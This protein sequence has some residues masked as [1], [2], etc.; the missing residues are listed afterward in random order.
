M[1]T[2]AEDTFQDISLYLD[3]QEIEPFEDGESALFTGHTGQRVVKLL[4]DYGGVHNIPNILDPSEPGFTAQSKVNRIEKIT[5]SQDEFEFCLPE[6]I[7][8]GEDYMEVEYVDG[9]PLNDYLQNPEAD[10]EELA[11]RVGEGLRELHERGWS[12]RDFKP[13]NLIVDEVLGEEEIYL[14]DAEFSKSDCNTTDRVWDIG[15]FLYNIE[16]ETQGIY[17]SICESFAKG[18]DLHP[19][20]EKAIQSLIGL[21]GIILDR[22]YE[23]SSKNFWRSR[24]I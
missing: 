15:S 7:H 6:V 24:T 9:T 13:E 23:E 16:A 2:G 21:Q 4:S 12:I 20:A 1:A 10:R 3:D 22:D 14:I 11:Y 19:R 8:Q 17:N 5:A 18:Y